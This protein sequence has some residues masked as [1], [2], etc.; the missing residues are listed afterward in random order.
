MI[1]VVVL[2]KRDGLNL[3]EA[4]GPFGTFTDASNWTLRHGG[5]FDAAHILT[6]NAPER[7]ERLY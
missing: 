1:I 7:I 4:Y 2:Y 5:L 3:Q 6:I